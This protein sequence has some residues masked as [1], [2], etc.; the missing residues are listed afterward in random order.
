[1]NI[2]QI[3]SNNRTWIAGKLKEDPDYFNK[4]S[5]GQ[6]PE[7]LYIGCC[8]SRVTAEELMGAK[9]GEVFVHRTMPNMVANTYLN[10]I[11]CSAQSGG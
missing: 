9:P 4:L 8:D 7:I 2:D 1:M 3:F 11:S 5:K 6:S 10:V